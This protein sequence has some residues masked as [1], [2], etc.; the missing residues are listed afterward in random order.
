[1]IRGFSR[2]ENS[3]SALS[4]KPY[5]FMATLD[6]IDCPATAGQRLLHINVLTIWG[7]SRCIVKLNRAISSASRSL[8]FYIAILL[9]WH[10]RSGRSNINRTLARE[11][12]TYRWWGQGTFDHID[13]FICFWRWGGAQVGGSKG[14]DQ[15]FTRW[16]QPKTC[17][18][19][20][21]IL[22]SNDYVF[23]WFLC[24]SSRLLDFN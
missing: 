5:S 14:S 1:M 7:N 22:H 24:S 19:N 6:G 18:Y 13:S 12:N 23:D 4:M 11:S 21:N 16:T 15:Y 10:M 9:I 17:R 2:S 20:H 8:N 3:I